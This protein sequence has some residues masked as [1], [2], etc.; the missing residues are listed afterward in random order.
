VLVAAFV[1]KVVLKLLLRSDKR[2]KLVFL[3]SYLYD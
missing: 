3:F 2:R 1:V